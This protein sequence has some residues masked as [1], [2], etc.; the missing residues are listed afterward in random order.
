MK[1]R[2]KGREQH[3]TLLSH[4]PKLRKL[5][6]TIFPMNILVILEQI[7]KGHSY[8]NFDQVYKITGSDDRFLM[9]IELG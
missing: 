7:W 9:D 4:Y 3:S 6:S 2:G 1:I 8:I 5:I